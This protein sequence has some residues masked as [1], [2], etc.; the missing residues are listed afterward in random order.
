MTATSTAADRIGFYLLALCV[1]LAAVPFGA[2][3]PLAAGGIG[4]V[5]A[6]CL[7][8]ATLSPRPRNEVSR[9]L[10]IA[11]LLSGFVLIWVF[12]QSVLWRVSPD[13]HPR[14]GP[15]GQLV[16][17]DPSQL[18]AV[19]TALLLS[20]GYLLLPLGAFICALLFIRD[21][22]RFNQFMHILVGASVVMTLASLAQFTLAPRALLWSD[23]KHYIDA[24]TGTF[25]NPNTAA[26]HFGVLLLLAVGLLLRQ[27]QL[28]DL[29]AFFDRGLRN[30]VEGHA[31]RMLSVYALASFVFL[32]SLL[33]TKSRGGILASLIGLTA[34]V[35]SFAF[36]TLKRRMSTSRTLAIV[37]LSVIGVL[38]AFLVLGERFLFRLHAQG[39]I[40]PGR[41]CTYRSTW[42]AMLD[43]RWLGTGLGTF[44]E[45]YPAYRSADCG[46]YGYWEMAHNLFLEGWLVFGVAFIVCAAL[47][48]HELIRALWRGARQRR[49]YRFAS[50]TAFG[51]LIVLTLH[52]AVDF[53]LQIPGFAV[54]AAAAMGSSAAVSLQSR[55]RKRPQSS[56]RLQHAIHQSAAETSS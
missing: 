30:P 33:L 23:K 56:Q 55:I 38:A 21:D 28:T 50:L 15:L 20:A 36:L 34:L 43:N 4:L 37:G 49:R 35:A 53:S 27:F 8:L 26:T 12:T 32:V 51:I 44:R 25:V 18:S 52:S 46:L 1:S 48:Y 54:L 13:I 42:N 11:F 31:L 19:R 2:T 29:H 17:D 41:E 5:L 7:L 16:A 47:A 9:L 14:T 3:D 10:W 40:D 6:V 24:F 39:L 45:V 22:A